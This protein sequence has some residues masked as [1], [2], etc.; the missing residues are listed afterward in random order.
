MVR[1]ILDLAFGIY[2][3]VL[4]FCDLEFSFQYPE[5][6]FRFLLTSI[7]ACG[8]EKNSRPGT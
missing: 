1:G 7:S 6:C 3:L 5:F 2:F 8:I 4:G